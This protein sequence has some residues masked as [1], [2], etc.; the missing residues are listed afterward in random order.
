MTIHSTHLSYKKTQQHI[1]HFFNS[2]IFLD[3]EMKFKIKIRTNVLQS[4]VSNKLQQSGS[5][6]QKEKVQTSNMQIT[7]IS[8]NEL[9]P[10]VTGNWMC[11]MQ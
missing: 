11:W 1:F 7:L 6:L 2:A 10:L 9:N 8:I 4:T 3:M 5:C